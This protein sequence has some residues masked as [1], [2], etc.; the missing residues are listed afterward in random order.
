MCI[1]IPR[2]W[3]CWNRYVNVLGNVWN[4]W[5][6]TTTML[7]IHFYKNI[8][9]LSTIIFINVMLLKGLLKDLIT[10]NSELSNTLFIWL[11][12]DRFMMMRF[13][14]CLFNFDQ[15]LKGFPPSFS[16]QF[17]F[18]LA[19]RSRRRCPFFVSSPLWIEPLVF[20][21]CFLIC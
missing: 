16:D 13:F 4:C 17:F 2:L 9:N 21:A 1:N 18:W 10:F 6:S 7:K 12:S 11:D 20:Y 3:V 19:A 14:H 15:S 5:L 8:T